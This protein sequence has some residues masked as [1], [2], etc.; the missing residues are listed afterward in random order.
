MSRE[1]SICGKKTSFGNSVSHAHNKTKRKFIPNLKL[2]TITENNKEKK[3]KVCTNCI[4][5]NK[6]LQLK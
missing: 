1:C 2:V 3:I 5:S 6:V 4:K